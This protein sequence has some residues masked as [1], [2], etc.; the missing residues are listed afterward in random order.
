MLLMA[1]PVIPL[2]LL[3]ALALS[4]RGAW[5]QGAE[6]GGATGAPSGL[7]AVETRKLERLEH[8]TTTYARFFGTF[9]AGKGL[10][11][12]NPYRLDTQLG[13]EATSA[14]LTAAYL[15]AGL[16]LTFGDPDGFQH[17]AS[18]HVGGAVEGVTQPF[19]TPGYV[20]AYRASLPAL[21]YARAGLPILLAPDPNVG[22]EIA[23]SGSYF[24]TSGLGLTSELA[25]DLFY[26][27]ATLDA[28]YSVIPVLSLSLGVIV[29]YEFL[30]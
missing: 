7:T 12:N 20:L 5:A 29:D 3:C 11:F 19:V 15:D 30:P 18:V 17:G 14:S 16:N 24:F 22:G 10:R 6:E 1:R 4:A 13:E 27:A 25:F 9:A 23:A 26:G 21:F 2:A 8:P 28:K